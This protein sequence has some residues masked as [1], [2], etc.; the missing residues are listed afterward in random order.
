MD[1][2]NVALE[3]DVWQGKFRWKKSR[4]SQE[5]KSFMMKIH[6]MHFHHEFFLLL[7]NDLKNVLI[8]MKLHIH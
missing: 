4:I 3:I 7:E 6:D 5:A 2:P 1:F 8:Y